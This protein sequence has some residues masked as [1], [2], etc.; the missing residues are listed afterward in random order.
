[1]RGV[2]RG[3]RVVW[4]AVVVRVRGGVLERLDVRRGSRLVAGGVR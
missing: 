2:V 3:G 1:M 4:V